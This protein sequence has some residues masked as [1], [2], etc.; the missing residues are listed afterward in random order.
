MMMMMMMMIN[1]DDIAGHTFFHV[2]VCLSVCSFVVV[3]LLSLCCPAGVPRV[4]R[5]CLVVVQLLSRCCPSSCLPGV[6]VSDCLFR[7]PLL[8]RCCSAVIPWL[9]CCCPAVVRLAAFL[10]SE[11]VTVVPSVAVRVSVCPNYYRSYFKL[12]SRGPCLVRSAG[13]R[14]LWGRRLLRLPALP[15]GWLPLAAW[16]VENLMQGVVEK[17]NVMSTASSRR[18]PLWSYTRVGSHT[19]AKVLSYSRSCWRKWKEWVA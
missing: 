9:S 10:G 19:K 1:G 16:P 7:F 11:C 12:K 13:S 2:I 17:T 14:R 3:P 18:P 5:S 15:R 8:S 4:S 6:S